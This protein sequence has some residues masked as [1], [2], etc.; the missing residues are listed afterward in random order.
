METHIFKFNKNIY[1]KTITVW[2]QQFIAN[3]DKAKD[4][5]ELKQLIHKK[6]NK[7][8]NAFDNLINFF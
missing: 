3:K 1:G 7:V 4:F 8:L 6:I 2:P 5:N